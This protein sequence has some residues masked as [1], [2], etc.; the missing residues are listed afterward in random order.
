M[1]DPRVVVAIPAR[2]G[3][4]RFPGKVLAPL[5]GRPVIAHVVE[6]ALLARLPSQVIVATDDERVAAAA[7]A[8]G[9]RVHLTAPHHPS[10]LDR[11]AEVARALPPAIEIVVN[12]Q[13]DEPCIAPEA[14]DRCAAPLLADKAVDIATLAHMIDEDAARDPNAVKVVC[15]LQSN[16]LYFSRHPIPFVREPAAPRAGTGS[17]TGIGST[18]GAAPHPWRH[19][20]HVGIYAYRRRALAE[21]AA[22]TPTALEQ[23]ERLEQLRALEHGMRI[24]VSLID[25][26]G[27]GVDT[28]GD[29]VR[30]AAY[31]AAAASRSRAEG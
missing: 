16:A 19:L 25:E 4:Q 20:R 10:G 5:E 14:I 21:L 28:E 15:D 27:P 26:T 23:A 7:A 11:I 1:S 6:R 2:F 24:R 12:L 22:A 17:G 8:A 18:A 30:A 13:G 29:L 31:L 9:A 3:S